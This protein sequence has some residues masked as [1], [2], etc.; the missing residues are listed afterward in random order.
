M[1]T[2]ITRE[3]L[4]A[5]PT[6]L[7]RQDGPFFVGPEPHPAGQNVAYRQHDLTITGLG[8]S[9]RRSRDPAWR[10]KGCRAGLVRSLGKPD[11][12]WPD[13]GPLI[14]SPTTHCWGVSAKADGSLSTR[15]GSN[16]G[17]IAVR[18]QVAGERV[19]GASPQSPTGL[20]SH[21][22]AMRM[23]HKASVAE[24]GDGLT[25]GSVLVVCKPGPG[26]VPAHRPTL[27]APALL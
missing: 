20:A 18:S 8:G 22:R 5:Y 16:G 24:R 19:P 4:E 11:L 21:S 13:Q 15:A 23:M 6:N 10:A 25:G 27:V 17:P 9:V 1:P 26:L 14:D 7:D 3:I 2:K 12:S